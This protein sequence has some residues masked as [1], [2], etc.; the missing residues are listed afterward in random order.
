MKWI[1][2]LLVALV[3][4]ASAEKDAIVL[5]ETIATGTVQQTETTVIP[6]TGKP[7]SFEMTITS[8]GTGTVSLATVDGYGASM[9]GSK[10][11]IAA[12][13]YIA[14]LSTNFAGTTYLYQDYVTLTTSNSCGI[15]ITIEGLLILDTDP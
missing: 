7:L 12:T 1:T 3:G 4:V 13:E 14:D 10:A 5:N 9:S 15:P 2:F 6:I 8:G 11:L